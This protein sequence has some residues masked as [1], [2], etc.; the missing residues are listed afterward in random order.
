MKLHLKNELTLIDS[1]IG[2][3]GKT[4]DLIFNGE[5]IKRRVYY[6]KQCGLYIRL[7]NKM[8]FEYDFYNSDTIIIDNYGIPIED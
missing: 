4:I 3:E 8:I 5:R 1:I 2:N 7:N 6:S